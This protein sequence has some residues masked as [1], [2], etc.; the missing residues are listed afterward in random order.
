MRHI[1]KLANGKRIRYLNINDKLA[2]KNGEL[3]EGMTVDRLHLSLKGYQVWA[4]ALKPCSRN[5]LG[6][7]PR[8]IMRAA[9]RRPECR[10]EG[11]ANSPAM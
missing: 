6:R 5:C 9:D 8:R 7:P 1:A 11:S 10:Q 2:D 4:D 3:F